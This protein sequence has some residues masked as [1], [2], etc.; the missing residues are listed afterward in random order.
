M[1]NRPVYFWFR[2]DL[3]WIDNCGFYHALQTGRPVIPLF[4]F[5][6][7]ILDSLPKTDRRVEFIHQ[8]LE[9]LDE[10]FKEFDSRLRIEV[11]DPVKI[12]K[13]LINNEDIHSVFCNEDYEPYALKRDQEVQVLLEEKGVEFHS[14]KDQVIFAKD[15]VLN[16]QSQPYK[17]FTPYSKK[18]KKQFGN[19]ATE[20]FR[21]EDHLASLKSFPQNPKGFKVLPSLKEL[22]FQA[23]EGSFPARRIQKRILKEYGQLRD[24]PAKDGTSRMGI[25]L[26]FGTLSVRKAVELAKENSEV[27]WNELI[28][29]EFFMMLLHH[30]SYSAKSSFKPE[31]DKIRWRDDKEDFEKWKMGQTGYPMVDAGMRELMQTGYMH[32]RVRMITASFLCKHLLIDWR[33]GEAWFAQKLLDY[34]MASNV[35]NW[36]WASGSGADAAPYFRIFNPET[37]MK[38]FDPQNEYVKKWVPEWG[39]DKYVEPMVEHAHA[40]QRAL[41]VYA[42][43]LKGDK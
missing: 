2:R 18:W 14:F 38:K 25:H 31:Y 40:R 12:W 37:Q 5:D 28:W 43:A 36:Q 34:E 4:I 17:V 16:D 8:S 20:H 6:R 19:V 15:E 32:N 1:Q 33:W 13:K 39:T 30:F 23:S 21:S 11:G 24:F 7:N 10:K 9:S 29:R 41:R 42:R 27:W 26:R 35:G 22:G 3:R